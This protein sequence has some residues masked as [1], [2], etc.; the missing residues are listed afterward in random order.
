M[1]TEKRTLRE[2]RAKRK[3]NKQDVSKRLGVAPSTYA[4]WESNPADMKI[5]DAVRISEVLECK[6]S[7]IIFF[8]SNPNLNLGSL[9]NVV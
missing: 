8:E 2:W 7:D 4:K 5:A 9:T 3:L 6:L 1:L